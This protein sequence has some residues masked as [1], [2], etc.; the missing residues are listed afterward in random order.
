MSKQ[1]NLG[2]PWTPYEDKLLT[3]AV[4]IYG[5]NTEKW[6][7]IA[8][9]VPGR[10]N[11]ACRKVSTSRWLHSLSP[12]VK[13]CAWTA[14]E[15]QLL[16]SL[17]EKHPNKW[18][19]IAREIA[20]RT[21]DACSKRY[22]E[23]LD[24][25]LIKYEW[26]EE[27]DK[28][29][30]EVLARHGGPAKPK[31]GL[32][33][34]ELRRSGLGCRN[35]WRLLERKKNATIRQTSL[36]SSDGAEAIAGFPDDVLPFFAEGES[37][38]YWGSHWDPSNLCVP[39]VGAHTHE[40]SCLDVMNF[41]VEEFAVNSTTTYTGLDS[42]HP[43]IIRGVHAGPI[44]VQASPSHSHT[45][46]TSFASYS[47][48][49][50][51][52]DIRSEVQSL[53]NEYGST[54]HPDEQL[55]CFSVS[56]SHVNTYFDQLQVDDHS[57]TDN[58]TSYDPQTFGNG[59]FFEAHAEGVSLL[60]ERHSDENTSRDEEQVASSS[61]TETCLSPHEDITVT[62]TPMVSTPPCTLPSLDF[63]DP[64]D[65][66]PTLTSQ[67]SQEVV[68]QFLP[69]PRKRRRTLA[70]SPASSGMAVFSVQSG[71]QKVMPKLSSTLIVAGDSKAHYQRALSTAVIAKKKQVND[72]LQFM[73]A[74][75]NVVDDA[76]A[77]E[78]RSK[79]KRKMHKCPYSD[80]SNEYKQLSGLRYHLLHG[81][82]K[83]LP[84]Q[85]DAVPP[86]IAKKLGV[87]VKKNSV[88]L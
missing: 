38:N 2:R 33:G 10:T 58:N 46:S 16:L 62:T 42:A 85:L 84:T 70:D 44:S 20:G 32:I 60:S 53:R 41:N 23:A 19:L 28:R 88:S 72:V 31:W 12:T 59:D 56:S 76:P 48:G 1:G 87:G 66:S 25:N 43:I 74:T 51:L 83:N 79:P 34:Q 17:H 5:E 45:G 75:G 73:E 36:S 15:D 13:K 29:L 35:R 69:P 77:T 63:I 27:E 82:P 71:K 6:K 24:P 30:L 22:R 40:R 50:A 65:I 57:Q 11:K 55:S 68:Q 39:D 80:C 52:S 86:T 78:S 61:H 8:L 81:H 21:D 3:D 37:S 18:S 4:Q 49:A 9:S 54:S 47:I 67:Q 64:L 26:S 7:T 14:E